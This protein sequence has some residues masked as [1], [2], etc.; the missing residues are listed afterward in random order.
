MVSAPFTLAPLLVLAALL[1]YAAMSDLRTRSID[2]WV[3]IAIALAAPAW[4]W[5]GGWSW[6]TVAWQAGFAAL[7]FAVLFGLWTARVLGGA[8][9]K[10]IAALAL[11]LPPGERLGTFFVIALA[12]AAVSLV[13]MV[14]AAKRRSADSPRAPVEIPYAVAIAA[15]GAA[16]LLRTVN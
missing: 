14:A 16:F 8:D 5:A 4:W 7:V 3:S 10:L 2:N 13:A 6:T 11:W 15:G 9:V 1:A 12:G